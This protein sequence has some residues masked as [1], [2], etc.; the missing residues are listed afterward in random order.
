MTESLNNE[1]TSSEKSEPAT[2][3]ETAYRLGAQLMQELQQETDEETDPQ[4]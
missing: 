4:S 2:D 3:E 1:P